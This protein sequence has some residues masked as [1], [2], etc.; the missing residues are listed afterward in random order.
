MEAGDIY[1]GTRPRLVELVG[2]LSPSELSTVSPGTP[3]WT[4]K[5]I[6]GH[7]TGVAADVLAGRVEGAGSPE[8]TARQV[9]ARKDKSLEEVLAEWS[10]VA[11]QF[12][13]LF[14]NVPQI[15]RTGYAGSGRLGHALLDERPQAVELGG[16][17]ADLAP[18]P[19][20]VPSA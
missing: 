9:A 14:E 17:V 7:V 19:R 15:A 10:E 5:D 18:Q 13:P 3:L 2:G 11:T 8:W 4:V 20:V 16:E 12:E 1:R 6:V